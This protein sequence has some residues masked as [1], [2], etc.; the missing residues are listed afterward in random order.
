[1][2]N[3]G[4]QNPELENLLAKNDIKVVHACTLVML[5]TGQYKS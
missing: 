1:I 2:F 5:K 3:P 4:T